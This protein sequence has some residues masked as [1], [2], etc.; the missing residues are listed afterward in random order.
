MV[1]SFCLFVGNRAVVSVV[2]WPRDLRLVRLA[3]GRQQRRRR[4]P[5]AR[6]ATIGAPAARPR[7]RLFIGNPLLL[8]TRCRKGT[9]YSA[10]CGCRARATRAAR[11]SCASL[12][13]GRPCG[14]PAVRSWL[15]IASQPAYSTK[16]TPRSASSALERSRARRRARAAPGA[17]V[18][19]QQL[20]GLGRVLLVRADHAARAALDPAGAVDAAARPRRRRR[21]TRPPS[22]GI[23][24]RSLVERHAGQRDAAVADAAEHE[25]RRGSPRARRSARRGSGRRRRRRARCGRPRSPRRGPRRGSRTGE[26]QKRSTQPL[27]LARRLA[28]GELAQDARRCAA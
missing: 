21:R 24:P 10:P 13:R 7:T 23:T 4:P 20:D 22:L 11:P 12:T 16:S 19:E 1:G 6:P 26:T 28:G 2:G 5:T 14:S 25:R 27:R 15:S 3:V 18:L 9:R 17:G 8:E